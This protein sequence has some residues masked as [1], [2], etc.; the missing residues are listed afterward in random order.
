M[1]Q[2]AE[3]ELLTMLGDPGIIA[4]QIDAF[5]RSADWLSSQHDRLVNEHSQQWVAVYDGEL[6]CSANTLDDLI[7][8]IEAAGL[9]RGEVVIGHIEAAPLPLIV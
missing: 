4:A 6:R 3:R 5:T 9:P 8:A 1:T 2:A 7:A